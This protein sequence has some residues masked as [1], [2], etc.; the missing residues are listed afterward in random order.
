M[1]FILT[2][3]LVIV[4]EHRELGMSV[5]VIPSVMLVHFIFS[6]IFLQTTRLV[7]FITSILTTLFAIIGLK[8]LL[9][10]GIIHHLFDIYG[11]WDI[12][13]IHLVIAIIIWEIA[14]QLLIKFLRHF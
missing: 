4:T 8:Y 5:A 14:Y 7:K 13:I 3:L 2:M 11:F 9:P 6:G 1:P 10:L 12:V